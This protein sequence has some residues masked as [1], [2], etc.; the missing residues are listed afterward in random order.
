VTG[1]YDSNPSPAT[2]AKTA[3]GTAGERT[4]TAGSWTLRSRLARRGCLTAEPLPRPAGRDK[5]SV[6]DRSFGVIG[7]L[8]AHVLAKPGDIEADPLAGPGRVA[9]LGK[10]DLRVWDESSDRGSDFPVGQHLPGG[11][12]VGSVAKPWCELQ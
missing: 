10:L 3:R 9:A 8:V 6:G 4:A 1:E 12:V 7:G 11:D 2:N 5:R